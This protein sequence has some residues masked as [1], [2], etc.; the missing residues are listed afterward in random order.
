VINLMEKTAKFGEITYFRD[1]ITNDYSLSLHGAIAALTAEN[2]RL[3]VT[4]DDL[5]NRIECLRW[6]PDM[7][8]FGSA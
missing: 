5:L 2:E 1:A 8:A 7:N 6:G 4:I 3:R